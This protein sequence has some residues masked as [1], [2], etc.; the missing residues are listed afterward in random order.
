MGAGWAEVEHGQVEESSDSGE[1]LPARL[2]RPSAAEKFALATG[3]ALVGA[4]PGQ[5]RWV[6]LARPSLSSDIWFSTPASPGL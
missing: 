5:R 4:E 3:P 1:K 6:P 2:P